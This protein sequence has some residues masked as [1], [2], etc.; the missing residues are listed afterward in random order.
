[1]WV[2]WWAINKIEHMILS[3]NI[4]FHGGNRSTWRKP[5]TCRKS[6][7][8]FITQ[9]CIECTSP[10][11]GFEL[12][13]LVV[14]GTG[15]TGRCK[16]NYHTITTMT[17]P[18]LRATGKKNTEILLKVASLNTNDSIHSNIS[19]IRCSALRKQFKVLKLTLYQFT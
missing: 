8:N 14:I 13:T 9:C 1:M 18:S 19:S 4:P 6:L 12:T 17:A 11:A 3:T 7:L 5:P 15:C 10:W 2:I 16:S